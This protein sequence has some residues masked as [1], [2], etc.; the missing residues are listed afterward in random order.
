MGGKTLSQ[1]QVVESGLAYFDLQAYIGTTK[2][3]GG[4][5]ATRELVALCHIDADTHVLDVGCGVGA[6]PCYLAGTYGARVVAID[7]REA[8]IAQARDRARREGVEALVEFLVADARHLPFKDGPFGVAMGESVASFVDDKDRVLYEAARVTGP[9]GHVGFNEEVWLKTPPP[10]AVEFARRTWDVEPLRPAGW[11]DV[12][13]HLGLEDVLF[14]PR[15]VNARREATQVKRYRLRDL[16]R[17]GIRTMS[18]YV[19][20]PTFR[21][22]MAERRNLPKDLFDYLGYVLIVGRKPG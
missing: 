5:A 6:T 18:L 21:K 2:H 8:M 10:G 17:M 15:T 1:E 11:V 9:G 12:L 3:M 20:R 19:R 14:E 16:I 13:E 4:L 7:V 22:Y